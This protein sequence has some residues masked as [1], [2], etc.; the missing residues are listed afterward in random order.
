M[1][2]RGLKVVRGRASGAGEL[3][4]RFPC[5]VCLGVS[6]DKATLGKERQLVLDH[7]RRCGGIWF[8]LGEVQRLRQLQPE[9]L[10]ERIGL[11]G[12]ERARMQCHSCHASMDRN[13]AACEA[14]GWGNAIACPQCDRPMEAE[15]HEGLRLDVCRSCKGVWFDRIE[16]AEIW[17]LSLQAS[18]DRRPATATGAGPVAMDGSVILLESLTYSPDLLF[19]GARAAGYAIASS[20]DVIGAAPELA[21]GALEGAADVAAGVFGSVL[22]MLEGL[23]S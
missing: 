8:E 22:E 4:P 1:R 5:P 23:F 2:K 11:R 19:F 21:S 15:M 3:L 12:A 9:A 6:M 20:A 7:C 18:V 14:C 17:K 13:A 16:L 10:F